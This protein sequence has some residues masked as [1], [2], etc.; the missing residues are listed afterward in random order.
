MAGSMGLTGKKANL[1]PLMRAKAKCMTGVTPNVCP[2]GCTD[3]HLDDFGYC[4]HLVGFSTDKKTMEP[5][6]KKNG[7]RVND[8][9]NRQPVLKTDR[10]ARITTSYRVYRDVKPDAEDLARLTE[11]PVPEAQAEEITDEELE[12][13]TRPE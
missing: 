8:G 3:A 10:L 6:L 1:S 9:K 4:H 12:Q 2:F 13:L 7:K 5:V 11:N